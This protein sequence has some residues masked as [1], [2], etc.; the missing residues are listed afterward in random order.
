MK[1]TFI[2]AIA[3]AIAVTGFAETT[4]L[5]AAPSSDAPASLEQL[6]AKVRSEAMTSLA[7]GDVQTVGRRGFHGGR[8]F[9][10]GRSFRGG[11][12]WGGRR[13]GGGRRFYGGRRWGGRRFYGGRRYYGG[14]R[15]YYGGG[16]YYGGRRWCGGRRWGYHR[17]GYRRYRPGFFIGIGF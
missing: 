16:R 14:G 12:G 6:R 8:G 13:Y 10:G 11:R 3:G 4:P 2:Y 9:R 15:Y 5:R 1:K 7:T 17:C